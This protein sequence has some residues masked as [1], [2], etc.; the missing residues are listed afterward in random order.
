[1]ESIMNTGYMNKSNLQD[2][3]VIG[4]LINWFYP[5]VDRK[6]LLAELNQDEEY[7]ESDEINQKRMLKSRFKI[8]LLKR[9][10]YVS[11]YQSREIFK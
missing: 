5:E 2:Y 8:A 4:V 6:I 9:K 10:K 3:P 1:M 11:G 7:L